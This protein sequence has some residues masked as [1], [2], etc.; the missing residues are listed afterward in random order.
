MTEAPT[1]PRRFYERASVNETGAGF[2][3]TLDSRTVTTP[4]GVAFVVPTR[5]LA[6]LCAD[7]WNAQAEHIVPATMPASQIAF[8]TLDWTAKGSRN[9]LVDYIVAFGET[10]L[11][12]HRADAP[13]ALVNRQAE[14]WDPIVSWGESKLG[15]RLPVVVG[16]IAAA[17]PEELSRL[18]DVVSRLPD[19]KLTALAQATG[20]AGSVLVGFALV[21][22]ALSPEQAFQAAALDDLWSLDHWGDDPEVRARLEHQQA[23]FK[24]IA[25]FVTALGS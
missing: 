8:A 24:A 15:V 13:S 6:E 18:R 20:L 12:C 16:I 9:D 7:E 17:A 10:D 22:G 21:S 19:L 2:G 4:G 23:E 5:A 11:C 14:L 25:R 3:V 1:L